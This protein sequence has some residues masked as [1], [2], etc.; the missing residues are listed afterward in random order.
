MSF[1]AFGVDGGRLQPLVS[2]DDFALEYRHL[3]VGDAINDMLTLLRARD[4]SPAR[5]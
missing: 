2:R 4:L 1:G 5:K 3:P